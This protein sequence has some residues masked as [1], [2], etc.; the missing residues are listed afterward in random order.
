[1]VSATVTVTGSPQSSTS[2]MSCVSTVEIPNA[3]GIAELEA[4][5]IAPTSGRA[6][7][8]VNF[9]VRNLWHHQY[10]TIHF[11]DGTSISTGTIFADRAAR[12]AGVPAQGGGLIDKFTHTYSTPGTYTMYTTYQGVRLSSSQT[13]TVTGA[14][15]SAEPTSNLASA[16]TALE[17]AL[18]GLLAKLK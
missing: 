18:N 13:I 3:N 5:M 17:A 7:L 8:A 4:A 2:A 11:G 6:P 1:M 16:L 10:D 12:C 14:S 15:A 9:W